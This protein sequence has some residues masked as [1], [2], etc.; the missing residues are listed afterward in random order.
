[1]SLAHQMLQNSFKVGI[2]GLGFV[3]N[4]IHKAMLKRHLPTFTY[5]KYKS[6]LDPIESLLNTNLVYLCLP[7]AYQPSTQDYD[8]S[9][10]LEVCQ[11]LAEHHYT[12]LVVIKSTILPGTCRNLAAQ[13]PALKIINN[14]EFL[15]ARTA[16]EDFEN[17]KQVVLGLTENCQL[18]DQTHIQIFYQIYF[19]QAKISITSSGHS[20]AMKLFCNSFYAQKVQIFNEF[21]LLSQK[22]E[23]D[24][25]TIVELMLNNGWI[26]PQHTTVPG[27]DGKLS[28]GGGCFV[29]DTQA[30]LGQMTRLQTPHQVL[31]A[32]IEERNQMRKDLN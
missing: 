28:Y 25:P 17:Q 15:T 31:S 32:C 19:P 22:L 24:Y 9:P 27:P 7:T 5:D 11:Y 4:A 6:D 18:A 21:Y 16:V 2:A 3:G 30:L 14:P 13:H 1:M 12:G 29:K 20:E 8:L 23:L 26:N 10:I